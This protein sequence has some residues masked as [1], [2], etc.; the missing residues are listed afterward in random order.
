MEYSKTSY[1]PGQRTIGWKFQHYEFKVVPPCG[2]FTGRL[3]LSDLF[4]CVTSR[5]HFH[6]TS[7]LPDWSKRTCFPVSCPTRWSMLLWSVFFESLFYLSVFFQSA[8]ISSSSCV[9]SW[10]ST[11]SEFILTRNTN[12]SILKRSWL[13]PSCCPISTKFTNPPHCRF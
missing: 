2:T 9:T 3:D 5:A 8:M 1:Y 12:L 7:V 10:S 6:W 11:S 4:I 13:P